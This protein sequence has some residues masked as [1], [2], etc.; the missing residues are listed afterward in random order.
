MNFIEKKSN[1]LKFIID[2]KKIK[3]DFIKINSIKNWKLLR[4]VRKKQTF[5]KFVNYNRKFIENY[6]K[7]A[8]FLI[9]L[10]VKNVS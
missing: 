8:I 1:F 4:N 6:L 5:I 10:I 3:I 7:K 9:K 2:N